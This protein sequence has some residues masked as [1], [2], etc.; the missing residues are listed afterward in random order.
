MRTFPL[1]AAVLRGG[2]TPTFAHSSFSARPKHELFSRQGLRAE[3]T[4]EFLAHCCRPLSQHPNPDVVMK[5][6]CFLNNRGAYSELPHSPAAAAPQKLIGSDK[7]VA[8]E[9]RKNWWL[10]SPKSRLP[11]PH[12]RRSMGPSAGSGLSAEWFHHAGHFFPPTY[13]FASLTQGFK[14][15]FEK[16]PAS[17]WVF[18]NAHS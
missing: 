6:S 5:Y 10:I 4:P 8:R 12:Q 11:F 14:S 16:P 18:L 13:L 7:K 15:I 9:R 3:E 1:K 17:V 2:E